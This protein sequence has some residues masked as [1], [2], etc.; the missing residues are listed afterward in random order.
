LDFLAGQTE[1]IFQGNFSDVLDEL[2]SFQWSSAGAHPKALIGLNETR[3]LIT[4][5]EK[6][7]EDGFG[8]WIVKFFH[9]SLCPFHR[10]LCPFHRGLCPHRPQNSKNNNQRL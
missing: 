7:L 2:L 1:E 9:R 10:G 3:D 6:E 8:P 5:G 4:H